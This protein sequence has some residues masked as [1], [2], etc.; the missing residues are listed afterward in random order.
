MEKLGL[1]RPEIT[2]AKAWHIPGI[3]PC[4]EYKSGT[5]V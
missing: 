1:T 2:W 4:E 3:S 5:Q